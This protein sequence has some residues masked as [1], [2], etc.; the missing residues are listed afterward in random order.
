MGKT[1]WSRY[2]VRERDVNWTAIMA[3]QQVR[4]QESANKDTQVLVYVVCHNPVSV[5]ATQERAVFALLSTLRIV[6]HHL[7]KVYD[8][9]VGKPV[10]VGTIAGTD[11]Y[12]VHTMYKLPAVDMLEIGFDQLDAYYMSVCEFSPDETYTLVSQKNRWDA[13][14]TRLLERWV[15]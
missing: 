3:A 9:Y 14:L 5:K 15:A 7:R 8:G 1:R 11:V 10:Y 2:G 13:D 12:E 4:L 6:Q